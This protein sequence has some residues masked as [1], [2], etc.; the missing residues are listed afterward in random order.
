MTS[1]ALQSLIAQAA[2]AVF[3]AAF[4]GAFFGIVVYDLLR[5]LLDWLISR[6]RPLMDLPRLPVDDLDA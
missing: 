4:F 1:A 3:W 2:H 5:S 6:Q